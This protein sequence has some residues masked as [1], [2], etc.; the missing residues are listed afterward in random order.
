MMIWK[1]VVMAYSRYSQHVLNIQDSSSITLPT[2]GMAHPSSG[3]EQRVTLWS[4]TLLGKLIVA[5]LVNKFF[6]FYGT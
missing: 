6:S 4:K 3:F 2:E 5:Y 1:E